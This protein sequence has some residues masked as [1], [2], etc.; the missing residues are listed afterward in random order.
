VSEAEAARTAFEEEEWPALA[1]LWIE[2]VEVLEKADQP[3]LQ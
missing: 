1:D 3:T 2:L